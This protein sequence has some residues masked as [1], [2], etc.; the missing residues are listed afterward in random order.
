[1]VVYE[2]VKGNMKLGSKE[3]NSLEHTSFGHYYM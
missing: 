2:E 3:F 1:L